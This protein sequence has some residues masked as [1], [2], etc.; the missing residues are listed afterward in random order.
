MKKTMCGS[1]PF[2]IRQSFCEGGK[3]MEQSENCRDFM[4]PEI[5]WVA[6]DRKMK[7][8]PT[9]SQPLSARP[10]IGFFDQSYCFACEF[11]PVEVLWPLMLSGEKQVLARQPNLWLFPWETMPIRWLLYFL[12]CRYNRCA[13]KYNYRKYRV[14]GLMFNAQKLFNNKLGI[15]DDTVKNR[16]LC[17]HWLFHS[18]ASCR[19]TW[20]TIWK[21]MI[22]T[23]HLFRMCQ[24]AEELTRRKLTVSGKVVCGAV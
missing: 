16:T 18:P 12:C 23:R 6:K 11:H 17:R 4:L 7:L 13:A 5:L 9:N 2:K 24:K 21:W 22:S 8:V 3:G 19:W 14:F 1:S 10:G 20:C 15:I